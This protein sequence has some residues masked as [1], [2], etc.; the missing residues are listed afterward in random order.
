MK[1]ICHIGLFFCVTAFFQLAKAQ[2]IL[3]PCNSGELF[4]YCSQDG[5]IIIPQ[6]YRRTGPFQG[7]IGP[8]VREDDYWWFMDKNGFFKFNTRKWFDE[9]PLQPVKGIYK[10]SY[11][12]PIF[13]N[14]TE[15]YNKD[16]NPIKVFSEDSLQNDTV[17]YKIFNA[18]EGILRAKSKLGTPYGQENLDCS[19]FVR[20]IFEPFG[21]TLPYY[22][23]EIAEKGRDIKL[24]D[25][26]PGDLVFFSGSQKTDS[27]INHV[28]FVTSIKGTEIEFIHASTS[29]GVVL[30]K[31]SD[32]Y[33]KSRFLFARRLIG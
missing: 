24:K 2:T 27:T 20:F 9:I 32:A 11:F 29:K 26:K 10:V 8:V 17:V 19:G 22:S 23:R 28:G 18:Q 1:I 31:I 15:Y 5:K 33:Y 21:I 4:G 16:G 3:K 13:A 25:L 7:S 30:N 6:I 14:V 12:D